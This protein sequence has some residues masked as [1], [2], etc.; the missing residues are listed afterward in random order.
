[1][2][3]DQVRA[4]SIG[5]IGDLG[6]TTNISSIIATGVQLIIAVAGLLFFF[7]L[8]LGGFKY[9]SSGGDEK[10]TASA[11]QSLTSAFIGLIIVVASFLVAQLI[12][13]LFKI[14]GVTVL[15]PP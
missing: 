7:M 2:F 1:M 12:F 11:R 8:L 4:Q 5:T 3:F 10:A 14:P 13:T 6:I 9:I 15:T